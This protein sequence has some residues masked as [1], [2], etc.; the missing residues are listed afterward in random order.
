IVC[1]TSLSGLIGN[2][3]QVNNSASKAGLI[4]AAKALAIELGKRKNTVN[5]VA[6]RLI[7]TAMLNENV[8]VDELMKMIP[9]QRKRKPE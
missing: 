1:I 4:G 3:R 8:T 6:P 9:A 7:D 5:C 2:R